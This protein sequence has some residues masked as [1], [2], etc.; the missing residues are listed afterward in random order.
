MDD[1]SRVVPPF[2]L[3]EVGQA[4]ASH[5]PQFFHCEIESP[6][7]TRQISVLI[8]IHNKHNLIKILPS[9]FF[10]ISNSCRKRWNN[11]HKLHF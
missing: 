11:E 8:Q 5:V 10:Q 9:I 3:W 1:L 2:A 6:T 7:K 4:P